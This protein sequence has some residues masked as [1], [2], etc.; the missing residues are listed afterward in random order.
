MCGKT[1]TRMKYEKKVDQERCA[2]GFHKTADILQKLHNNI[3]AYFTIC[4]KERISFCM[5]Y[6]Y[7]FDGVNM[8]KGG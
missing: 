3:V 1:A 5:H 7:T 8:V 4:T 6:S 2:V